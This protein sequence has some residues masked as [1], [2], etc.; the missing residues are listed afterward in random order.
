MQEGP[1]LEKICE[2]RVFSFSYLSLCRSSI[3]SLVFPAFSWHPC[4]FVCVRKKTSMQ[5]G[6]A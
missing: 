6:P 3:T 5:V 4:D 2:N 1:Q